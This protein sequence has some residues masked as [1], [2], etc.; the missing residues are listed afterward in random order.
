M[1]V[2]E[3]KQVDCPMPPPLVEQLPVRV[4]LAE[5]LMAASRAAAPF[6]GLSI[7]AAAAQAVR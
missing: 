7:A 3:K 2:R 5:Q 4:L 6:P 1:M